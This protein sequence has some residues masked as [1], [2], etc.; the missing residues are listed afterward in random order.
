MEYEVPEYSKAFGRYHV[1][2]SGGTQS[3]DEHILKLLLRKE[4][5]M[6]F[7]MSARPRA[8]QIVQIVADLCMG[9]HEYSPIRGQQERMDFSEALR[10]GM[11]E[12]MTYQPLTWDGGADAEAFAEFKNHIADMSRHAVDGLNEFF[13][14]EELEGE[15][16]RY[17]KDPRIDVP[18]TLFLDYASE[19]RQ[20]DLKCSLPLRNPPKKDGSRTWRVPKPKT[21]P[22]PQQVMQQAVYHKSTGLTPGLLFVTSA[23]YNIVTA[24]N[25]EALQPDRLE[26]AYENVV[27][28]WLAVQKLMQVANG[29][30]RELFAL[31]PPDFGQIAQ[32]H[33]GEIL[34]I[35]K[36]AW[37]TA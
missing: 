11:A 33:G 26:E 12:F 18:V 6:N 9:L 8:G 21:E 31:V 22:T 14:D 2:A 35:A 28:R 27:R 13:G 17:Y 36:D 19:A 3:L 10:H 16:Q 20:I 24:E 1:S 5:K 25:C 23:G 32:R 30:W 7:P 34:K 15:Y 29:N 37:R 4:Y